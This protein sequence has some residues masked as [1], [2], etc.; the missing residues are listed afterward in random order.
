MIARRSY[1]TSETRRIKRQGRFITPPGRIAESER[2]SSVSSSAVV[3]VRYGTRKILKVL[4]ETKP[5][6]VSFP[7]GTLG[8]P[9]CES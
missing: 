1:L 4:M 5:S 3:L 8:S 7:F 2:G 6:N 9:Q